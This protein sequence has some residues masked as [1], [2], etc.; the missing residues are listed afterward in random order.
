MSH[1]CSGDRTGYLNIS[2][3][4]NPPTSQ[5]ALKV[6]SLTH[7]PSHTIV[8]EAQV[9]RQDLLAKLNLKWHFEIVAVL[10]SYWSSVPARLRLD[11]PTARSF[12]LER[13]N[14]WT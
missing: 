10:L 12:M 1:G 5:N 9:V 11:Q 4:S 6:E 2:D 14:W 13:R 8:I 3:P 7:K